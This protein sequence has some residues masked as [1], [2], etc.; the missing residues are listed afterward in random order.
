[1]VRNEADHHD[2]GKA[3]TLQLSPE[4]LLRGASPVVR[5]VQNPQ[6][7]GLED[8]Q[9]CSHHDDYH[10]YDVVDGLGTRLNATAKLKAL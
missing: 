7:I 10:A 1:M 9:H 2:E 8:C 5:P 3:E 4:V 6:D